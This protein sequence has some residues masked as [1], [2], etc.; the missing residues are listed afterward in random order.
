[1]KYIKVV[2]TENTNNYW[3]YEMNDTMQELIRIIDENCVEH[4]HIPPHHHVE[5][6]VQPPSCII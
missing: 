5:V 1:M 2:E 3:Y 4:Q 6:D